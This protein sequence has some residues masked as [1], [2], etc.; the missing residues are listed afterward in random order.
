MNHLIRALGASALFFLAA[1]VS[2]W[3]DPVPPIAAA[4]E[5]VGLSSSQ[6][7]RIEAVTRAKRRNPSRHKE[8]WMHP[9]SLVSYGGQV[10]AS[11]L[12]MTA[13]YWKGAIHVRNIRV[14]GSEG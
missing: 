3:A 10:V 7:A 14:I 1:T 11:L 6:L 2:G 9:P 12:A 4:P 8:E 5:D 13:G